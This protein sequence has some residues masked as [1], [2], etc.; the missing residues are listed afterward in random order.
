MSAPPRE[1]AVW[2]TPLYEQFWRLKDAAPG[3]L[4]F[5]RLGDFYE[6]FGEDALIAAP[7]LE[8]QL[9][10][11]DKGAAE[12]IPMC[13]VPAHAI[14]SYAEKLLSR[15]RKVALSE[16]LT[17]PAESKSKLVERG[18]VRILTP[19]LPVDFGR[20]A[21]REPHW[22]VVVGRADAKNHLTV[23]A[24]DFLA[25]ALFEGTIGS[26]DELTDLL[27]RLHAKEILLPTDWC[28]RAAFA[29]QWPV[30]A[31]GSR[32]R[33]AV[34]PWTGDDANENLRKYLLYTQRCDPTKL[35]SLLPDPRDLGELMGRGSPERARVPGNVFE[36]WAVFPELFDL[37]DAAGS[38]VGS[39]RLRS[40]LASPLRS[41]DRLRRRQA[42]FALMKSRAPEVL[43]ASRDVYDF[44]RLL[45]RFRV[46]VAA[47]RELVRF[48][49]SFRAAQRALSLAPVDEPAWRTLVGDEGLADASLVRAR[50]APLESRLEAAINVEVDATRQTEL[51][52]LIRA[53]F[54]AEFDRLRDLQLNGESWLAQF[55][56]SLRA[57]TNIPSLKV[58][59]NRVFGHYIEVTKA[60]LDKVP[61]TF[62]RK[63]TTVG[64]ERF[65]NS[66]L[67]AKE[68]E[69]LTAGA[70]AEAKAREILE[71]LQKNI[72]ASESDLRAFVDHFAWAD[73][74]AGASR[75]IFKQTRWGTWA[76]PALLDGPFRFWLKEARHPI[77]E[78]LAGN[79]VPN[80]LGLGRDREARILVLT[81][82]NMAGK[83]TLMRQT[84]LCLLLAQCGFDVPA[85][86]L[87]LA[88]A[89]GFYSR[90][91]ATD[92][93]LAGESTFMVE[94]RETAQLLRA[95]DKDSLI[96]LD[97]I[98]RGTS[99]QD[100]LSIAQ[101]V[102]EHLHDTT[103]ALCLFATHYHELSRV[104][105]GLP[106]AA[107]GSMALREWKGELV[108]LRTLEMKPAESSHGI[109]VAKMAGLPKDLVTRAQKL[110]NDHDLPQLDLGLFGAANAEPSTDAAPVK[111]LIVEVTKPSIV[112]DEL[113]QL[114]LN[115]LSP[116]AAWE[117]LEALQ[118]K[119]QPN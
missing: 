1:S 38:A 19:G 34:T 92:R 74:I 21:A 78:S 106:K 99:T 102:L 104:A 52:E 89:S 10:S 62:E 105:L 81:G 61:A 26:N 100:G 13:G 43:E 90:M 101:A 115:D 51:V 22:F 75:G 65:T 87:E 98:G 40:I 14:E 73:A 42:A 53:G 86:S 15:G 93:I 24:F 28:D 67:R 17:N 66:E 18:L 55:E 12:P 6:L 36:H 85:E 119:L 84:G 16:Q 11:R 110:F 46:G 44:E 80:S 77:I 57:S 41:A 97:E 82:P 56:E 114:D 111:Q 68:A 39:R 20:L 118:Q 117:K 96:L 107:N 8:V 7:L 108:F 37:L 79:F 76:T 23:L 54:D 112:E 2:K 5:F 4:L 49:L 9:T 33:A 116:K 30:F 31:E 113:A 64:G 95:A 72:L 70:R 91:G 32:W 109:F 45:G 48:V 59:Y 71:S 58:R 63:Q 35:T 88:P 47:P 50:L 60:N 3:C 69:I 27:D 29:T 83:S 103:G 94:M 25:G